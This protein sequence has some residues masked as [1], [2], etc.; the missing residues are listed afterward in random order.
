MKRNLSIPLLLLLTACISPNNKEDAIGIEKPE[1]ARTFPSAVDNGS[2]IDTLGTTYLYG[3]PEPS[4]H[5][6]FTN[7]SLEKEQFNFGIGREE[8]PALLQ[9]NF[10]TINE[11]NDTCFEDDTRFLFIEENGVKKAYSIPD[12]TRSEVVND[13]INGEPIM[14]AYCVLADLGAIYT[15]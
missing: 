15:R 11:V 2:F 8:F 14:A 7:C 12:L 3:G 5:F 10:I 4:S 1:E 13:E 6:D 9:P